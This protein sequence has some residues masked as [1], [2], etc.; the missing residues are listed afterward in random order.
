MDGRV[1]SALRSLGLTDYQARAYT[2]LVRYGEL[3]AR[4]LSR[5]S[6]IPYSK[7]YGVL[8]ALRER[9]WIGVK[10]GRPKLYYPKPPAEAVRAEV[11][12][13]EAELKALAE[14]VLEELQPIYERSR[15]RERP[16]IWIIRGRDAVLSKV[17]E[18]LARASR[19]V[20]L[21]IPYSAGWLLGLLKPSI[22]HL[23]FSGLRICV[24]A[25]EDLVEDRELRDL[26]GLVEVRVRPGMFGGGV[27]ADG[28][29]AVL[30]LTD[31]GGVMAIWSDYAELAHVAK[32]Y[33]GY[34]WRSSDPP[35]DPQGL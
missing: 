5:L 29:E 21:A 2:T 13:I 31:G 35:D 27:I 10:T 25:S 19:E 1:L 22:A 7:V 14:Q 18:V 6:G 24:L 4:E 34:L 30:V 28:R 20:L 16:D 26:E 23:R 32:V 9:G 8:E 11:A 12:R 17:R 33:F 3:G 15:E